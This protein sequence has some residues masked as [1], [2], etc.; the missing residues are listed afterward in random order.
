[1]IKNIHYNINQALYVYTVDNV[2]LV[3]KSKI[4]ILNTHISYILNKD[5]CNIF[6]IPIAVI[7]QY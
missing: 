3:H 6:L 2:D 4:I 5:L 1:M 7:K